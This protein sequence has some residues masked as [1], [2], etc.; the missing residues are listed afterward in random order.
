MRFRPQDYEFRRSVEAKVAPA[1]SLEC[2]LGLWF[3]TPIITCD[4]LRRLLTWAVGSHHCKE[5][6][7][8]EDR[9]EREA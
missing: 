9:Q 3:L 5:I 1:P 6:P 8:H 7:E 2:S 4:P